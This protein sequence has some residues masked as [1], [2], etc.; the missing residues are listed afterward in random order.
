[1]DKHKLDNHRASSRQPYKV[2][3]KRLDVKRFV[4]VEIEIYAVVK[5]LLQLCEVGTPFNGH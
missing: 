5:C 1:M 3:P 2:D 4:W